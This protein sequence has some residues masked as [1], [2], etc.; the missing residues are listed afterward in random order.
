MSKDIITIQG[1]PNSWYDKVIFVPKKNTQATTPTHLALE[2]EN[3]ITNHMLKMCKQTP[4]TPT[5]NTKKTTKKHNT[6]VDNFLYISI[7]CCIISMLYLLIF[8]V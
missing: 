5:K 4:Y 6:Y 3:I 1:E 2:A 8:V 7:T